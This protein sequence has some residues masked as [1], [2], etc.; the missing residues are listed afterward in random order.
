MA[1]D[2]KQDMVEVPQDMTDEEMEAFA[3]ALV[4]KWIPAPPQAKD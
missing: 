3:E 2:K 4:R 1:S